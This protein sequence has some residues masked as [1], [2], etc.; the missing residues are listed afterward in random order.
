M[1]IDLPAT[2]RA[3]KPSTW[4]RDHPICSG[5]AAAAHTYGWRGLVSQANHAYAYRVHTIA[6]QAP[7]DADTVACWSTAGVVYLPVYGTISYRV[8][9]DVAWIDAIVDCEDAR[10]RVYVDGVAGG[11]TAQAGR[12]VATASCAVTG[13]QRLIYLTARENGATAY[14]YRWLLRERVLVAGDI[15]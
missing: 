2:L 11:S 9:A 1:A 10:L 15:P 13:G 5:Q 6:H 12:G 7:L 8:G 3:I 14:V 4:L